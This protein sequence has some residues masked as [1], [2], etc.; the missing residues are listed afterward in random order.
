MIE[1]R[2]IDRFMI[3]KRFQGKG[4]GKLAFGMLIEKIKNDFTYKEINLSYN[5]SNSIAEN[6]Y[7]SFNFIKTGK[8]SGNECIAVLKLE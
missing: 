4:Y 5:P 3:D 6:L 2:K 1:L 7:R 8:F